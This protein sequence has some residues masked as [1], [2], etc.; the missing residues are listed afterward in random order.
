MKERENRECFRAVA[1]D[2]GC[3]RDK[4]G[5]TARFGEEMRH[6]SIPLSLLF[7]CVCLLLIG[8]PRADPGRSGRTRAPPPPPKRGPLAAPAAARCGMPLSGPMGVALVL[9]DPCGKAR[10]CPQAGR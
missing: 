3:R 7:R 5:G 8:L 4:E 2:P 10:K 1:H 9:I 6:R